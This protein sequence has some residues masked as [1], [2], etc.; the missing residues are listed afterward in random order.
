LGRANTDAEPYMYELGIGGYYRIIKVSHK[1]SSEG[2][3]TS[4]DTISEF[5]SREIAKNKIEK[6][7]E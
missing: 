1:L 6:G 3:I 5:S 7:E 4:L 2:F